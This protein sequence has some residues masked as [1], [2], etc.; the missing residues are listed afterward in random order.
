MPL[1]TVASGVL[2]IGVFST[3]ANACAMVSARSPAVR[4]RMRHDRNMMPSATSPMSN[5]GWREFF[6]VMRLS[7]ARMAASAPRP[8][9]QSPG[10]SGTP[11]I[12]TPLTIT[13]GRN[14]LIVS[15]TPATRGTKYPRM[16]GRKI[17]VM[18]RGLM[19]RS[20]ASIL[21][22]FLPCH[23]NGFELCLVRGPWIVVKPVQ[24]DDAVAEIGKT[25]G[26]RVDAL[27]LLGE[28]DADVL[29]IGPFHRAT[30]SGFLTV[31]LPS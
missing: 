8:A 6:R 29:G 22:L 30:S 31:D 15:A 21:E 26:E 25:E 3:M 1:P 19:T 4:G 13:H 24:R 9:I 5:S 12:S 7:N 23:L 18:P 14:A 20:M 10:T 28:R 16:P 27:K 17:A 11:F 2:V